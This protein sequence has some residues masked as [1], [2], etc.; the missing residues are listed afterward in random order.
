MRRLFAAVAILLLFTSAAHA[1][2]FAQGSKP[3]PFAAGKLCD[4]PTLRSYGD[5]V[6]G[7]SSKYDL[8]F[9]PHDYPEWIWRCEASGF[10]S[11]PAD[12]EKIGDNE[13]PRIAA[14]LAKATFGPKVKSARI[15]DQLL[16]HLE[17][18]YAL[19]DKDETFHAYFMR[20][21][22]WQY[23]VKPIADKYR[24][25]A[26]DL[27]LRMLQG[28]AL[29]DDALLDTL[30]I[31]GFYSYKFGRIDEAKKYFGRMRDVETLDPET[32]K[33]RRGSPYLEELAQDVLNG[34]A[35]DKV[36]F[37]NEPN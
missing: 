19:R 32:K 20:Y 23:R 3:D 2:R 7:W 34:K 35:D 13:R 25:K 18:V 10:V 33:P 9:S 4:T 29:K 21:L 11:F 6:Y 8:I 26:F 24:K 30:Y 28:G 27:H 36:R 14:Y 12:F 5:Y 22:V 31:L 16:Q 1:I 17:Q 37:K 15:S